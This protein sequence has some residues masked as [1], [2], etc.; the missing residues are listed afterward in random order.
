MLLNLLS[1]SIQSEAL[2]GG[3]VPSIQDD[4]PPSFLE[5]SSYTHPESMVILSSV[6]SAMKLTRHREKHKMGL[7]YPSMVWLETLNMPG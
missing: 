2:A 4:L 7:A 5:S 3:M 1:L 6:K